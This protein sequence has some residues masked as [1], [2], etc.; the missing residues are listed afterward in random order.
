MGA[1]IAGQPFSRQ[2]NRA[3]RP[4]FV[5]HEV[6]G[7]ARRGWSGSDPGSP[8]NQV[9]A[10][11]TPGQVALLKPRRLKIVKVIGNFVLLRTADRRNDQQQDEA[12][13]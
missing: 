2:E 8:L 12:V 6:L 7:G 1:V 3:V 11:R 5:E 10:L 4:M 9:Q 13:E